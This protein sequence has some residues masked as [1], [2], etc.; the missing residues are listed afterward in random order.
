MIDSGD[1]EKGFK[2]WDWWGPFRSSDKHWP[3]GNNKETFSS[4]IWDRWTIQNLY[5]AG[6]D[7][8]FFFDLTDKSGEGFT[9]VVEDCV[10]TGR[11]F[12]GG[13]AY[14][15]VRPGEPSVF[16]RCYFLA[17][18]WVGDTAA[19]LVGG[20]EKSM[21]E[22]PHA[23]FE[24]C[25][26]VHPDN[27]V[28]LSY[29]SH[30]ARAKFVSCRMIVLNFT[31]PEMGGQ[32][33]GIICTEHHAPTGSCM[34]TWRIASWPATASSRPGPEGDAVSFTTKGKVQAYVQY[35]QPCRKGSSGWGSGRRNCFTH[36]APPRSPAEWKNKL[37]RPQVGCGQIRQSARPTSACALN[38]TR[39]AAM[40]RSTFRELAAEFLGTFVLI[41]FG[42]G[43]VAQV[44][45]SGHE[46]G[47]YLSINIGWALGVVLGVYVA[48]GVSGAHL[49]PAVTL[50][51]AVH[52]RFAWGKL[53]PYCLAQLAGAFVASI[54]VYVTYHDALAILRPR[55]ASSVGRPGHG[56]YLGHVS[57]TVSHAGHRRT[58]RPDRGY[59]AADA[60][61]LCT[62]R[63][64]QLRRS[65]MSHRSWWAP[66]CWRS[67]LRLATTLGTP[68]IPRATSA[69]VSSHSSP[70]GALKCSAPGTIGGGCPSSVR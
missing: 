27:A 9:I 67:A 11:A 12:G 25:T 15:I 21:P 5:V 69:P 31:Q 4:I 38:D 39:I 43:S 23:V 68:S 65:R 64:T 20:W 50:A 63:Q 44:L 66:R 16:R 26:L 56:R 1:P 36:M 17:L 37:R 24:D 28:A 60:V 32:S 62:Q 22:H 49:N 52:R 61:H 41:V 3:A 45:L 48:A 30:C 35:K 7:G 13:V 29:A 40:Q 14:P 6:G 55:C 18:D 19:V 47:E 42:C 57:A 34:W 54:V 59:G 46:N 8:G 58:D 10:G 33:T 2:S 70:A 53:L 51:L